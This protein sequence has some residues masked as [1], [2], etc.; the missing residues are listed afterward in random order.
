MEIKRIEEI[1]NGNYFVADNGIV[2]RIQILKP[3]N[4]GKD[5]LKIRINENGKT[6]YEYIHRLVYKYFGKKKWDES[7]QINHLDKDR[8]NNFI[9]NLD[10]V[11]LIENI[12]HRDGNTPF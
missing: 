2:F 7:K 5:Y 12:I 1:K 9:D 10:L 8:Q 3:N 4:N 6:F 11:S